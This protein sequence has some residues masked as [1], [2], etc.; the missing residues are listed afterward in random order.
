MAADRS[1]TTLYLDEL[2]YRRLK[3]LARA[4]GVSPAALVREAMAQYVVQ[5]DKGRRPRSIGAGAS[6]RG[7]LSER[8]EDLLEGFGR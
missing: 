1:K 7:D 3:A 4:R 2:V 5:H 6:R 8:A